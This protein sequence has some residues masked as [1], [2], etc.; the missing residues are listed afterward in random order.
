MANHHEADD[1]KR[2][3]AMQK[4][5][6]TLST[7]P[8]LHTLFSHFSQRK[9]SELCYLEH[10]ILTFAQLLKERHEALLPLLSTIGA[11]AGG[12]DDW[13]YYGR[14]MANMMA[15]VVARA[16]G[17]GREFGLFMGETDDDGTV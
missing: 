11:S 12:D 5:D 8:T 7:Q 16:E 9:L 15:L 10:R 13:I 14:L 6:L 17:W 2:V 1:N 4:L 3:R